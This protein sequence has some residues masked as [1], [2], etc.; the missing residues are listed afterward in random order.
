MPTRIFTVAELAGYG[1]PPSDP[2][3]IE[4]DPDL[5]VDEQV[6]TLKYTAQRRCIFR[7]D[8]DRTYAVEYEAPIDVGDFEVGG[9]TPDT[10]GWHGD[11]VPAVEV[12]QR[13]V[14]VARW[15]PVTD[16]PGTD[17]PR[18]G[19]LE[20]LAA[21]WFTE[22]GAREDVARESAAAW[23][24]QHADEIAD[25]HDAYLATADDQQ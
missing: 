8:D 11:T 20:S 17:Q 4:Y 24:I 6:T 5:L 22:A 2:R 19:A 7:A 12:E 23:I 13:P 9:G 18:T 16:E 1:V 21:I 3:D 25:L 14:I 10:R 15:C